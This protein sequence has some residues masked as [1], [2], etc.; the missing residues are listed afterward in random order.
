M[1]KKLSIPSRETGHRY[2]VEETRG[3]LPASPEWLQYSP[4]SSSTFGRENETAE[5]QQM[6]SDRMDRKPA[7]V[8]Y[9]VNSDV[10]LEL[11]NS[12]DVIDFLRSVMFAQFRKKDEVEVTAATSTGDEF[13]VASGGDGYSAGDLFHVETGPNAG[14]HP[15][16]GTPTAT[17]VPVT[18]SLTNESSVS[19]VGRRVGF[20]FDAG[21]LEVNS[22]GH[23]ITTAKDCTEL[24]LLEGEFLAI[25][26]DE[27]DSFFA[28]DANNTIVRADAIAAN[29]ITTSKP[30]GTLATDDGDGKS[31]RLF[32]A[33]RILKNEADPQL[34]ERI[35]LQLER[36]MGAPDSSEPTEIQYEYAEGMLANEATITNPAAGLVTA[37][38]S[39]T[40]T[41]HTERDAETGAKSGDRPTADLV[42]PFNTANNILRARLGL[43]DGDALVQVIANLSI[44]ITN[45]ITVLDGVG[46]PAF[47]SNEGRFQ[48]T[49][50]M[51]AYFQDFELAKAVKGNKT[52]TF[53]IHWWRGNQGVSLDIPAMSLSGGQAEAVAD[54]AIRVPLS[55]RAYNGRHALDAL[56]HAL[57]FSFFS[58]LPNRHMPAAQV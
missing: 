46:E 32:F 42:D 57:M 19:H 45:N 49:G 29:L 1:T 39:L 35:S 9:R 31:V 33:S 13:T 12:Q 55:F 16:T 44:S 53:D 48:V 58:Y 36:R 14:I 47:D 20:E 24:G 18:T 22:D 15:V 52:A 37:N 54:D 27:A 25:G 10:P 23:L 38:F 28:T 6:T 5:S 8:S 56:N 43:H 40:G 21:D 26:G 11:S 7:V 34:V 30:R 2:A 51:A 41:N 4:T 50:D 17:T 3:N